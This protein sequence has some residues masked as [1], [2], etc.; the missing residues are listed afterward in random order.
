MRESAKLDVDVCGMLA[1]L[2]RYIE[3]VRGRS[4]RARSFA[5]GIFEF[6]IIL[7]ENEFTT[8][9]FEYFSVC[10]RFSTEFLLMFLPLLLLLLLLLRY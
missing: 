7:A 3:L 10:F 5:T 8:Q 2:V 9:R 6:I 1:V 4:E